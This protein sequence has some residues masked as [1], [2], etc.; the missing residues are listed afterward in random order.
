MNRNIAGVVWHLWRAGQEHIKGSG[1]CLLQKEFGIIQQVT[2]AGHLYSVSITAMNIINQYLKGF[3]TFS[4][5]WEVRMWDRITNNLRKGCAVNLKSTRIP[6]RHSFE[7]R[8]H[9]SSSLYQLN[10]ALLCKK[11]CWYFLSNALLSP[12]TTFF[13]FFTRATCNL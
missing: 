3:M 13:F 9:S 12:T 7:W 11:I 1:K 10:F 4:C 2:D 8:T 6:L 5:D